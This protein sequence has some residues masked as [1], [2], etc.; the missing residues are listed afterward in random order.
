MQHDLNMGTSVSSVR[1]NDRYLDQIGDARIFLVV[2]GTT[3]R[4]IERQLATMPATRDGEEA[5]LEAE[6]EDVQLYEIILD[7]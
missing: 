4:V 5:V 7:R 2:M 6:F 3:P 1:I